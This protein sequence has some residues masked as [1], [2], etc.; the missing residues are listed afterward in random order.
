MAI[1]P[2]SVTELITEEREKGC[3]I[4]RAIRIGDLTHL[5]IAGVEPSCSGRFCERY[6]N[7]NERH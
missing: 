7:E 6:E 2:T 5:N 3:A 4:F 1:A